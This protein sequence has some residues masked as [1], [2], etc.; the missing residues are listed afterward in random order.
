[1][2]TLPLNART[3][4]P[5]AALLKGGEEKSPY[6]SKCSTMA[7]NMLDVE[8]TITLLVFDNLMRRQC[9]FPT[10]ETQVINVI[11]KTHNEL[12]VR[13]FDLRCVALIGKIRHF[14]LDM[15]KCDGFNRL[16]QRHI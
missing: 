10:L 8:R 9:W 2:S 5:T 3:A 12:A 16:S 13:K 1:M 14:C 11:R 6:G 15:R 7:P 4:A